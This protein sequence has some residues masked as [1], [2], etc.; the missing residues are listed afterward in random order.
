MFLV[1]I[2]I[3]IYIYS[4]YTVTAE[5]I[6]MLELHYPMIQF[7]IIK[8]IQWFESY[9][10]CDWSLP[11]IY[12]IQIHGW[13]HGKF[14]SSSLFCSNWRAVL[15]IFVRLFRIKASESFE[16]NLSRSYLQRKKMEKRKHLELF[17]NWEGLN[18]KKFSQQL[19]SCVIATRDS[20]FCKMFSPSLNILLR[21]RKS[22]K[23]LF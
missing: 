4:S 7:L 23:K 11:V 1:Y 8:F 13:R 12:Q 14:V 5:P 9:A 20:L 6:K 22:V 2:Y 19:P 15:K 10:R 17:T 18:Y 21:A 3:Y 16:Q